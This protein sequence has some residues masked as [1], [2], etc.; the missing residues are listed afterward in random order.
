MSLERDRRPGTCR[1]SGSSGAYM[2]L[3]RDRRP[4]TCRS[5]G[6][7]GGHMSL[8][9]DRRPGTCRS[10][11]FCGRHMSLRRDRSAGHMSLEPI[12]RGA[13]VA[14]AGSVGRVHVAVA[15]P[16]GAHVAEAGSAGGVHVAVARPAGI[17]V[18]GADSV[19]V[20]VPAGGVTTCA[21]RSAA[22]PVWRP[23]FPAVGALRHMSLE[24][25]RLAGY[26]SE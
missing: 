26:L 6:S 19:F 17:H 14:G 25:G 16:A 9:R 8:Q 13:H 7:S 18:A 1:S 23:A 11:G 3:E 5:S 21:A 4:G 2:S 20:T 24:R 15:D 10:S 12:L 22:V